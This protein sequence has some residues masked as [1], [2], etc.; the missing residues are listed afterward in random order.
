MQYISDK[1]TESIGS[2][3]S[4]SVG[5]DGTPDLTLEGFEKDAAAHRSQTFPCTHDFGSSSNRSSAGN[6]PGFEALVD[7]T[8]EQLPLE[9]SNSH[10]VCEK[11]I[12]VQLF[13]I[14][15]TK[16]RSEAHYIWTF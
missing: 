4:S 14:L 7:S 2:V 3:V 12:N 13:N 8:F 11:M 10:Q 5:I 6:E 15:Q 9:G 16:R 1:D